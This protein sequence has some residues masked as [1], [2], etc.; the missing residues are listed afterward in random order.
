MSDQETGIPPLQHLY[1]AWSPG[2]VLFYGPS[3]RSLNCYGDINRQS[4]LVLISQIL[5]LETRGEDPI[6]LY[7][8]TDG[9]VLADALA[10]YDTLRSIKSPIVTIATGVCASA[11]LLLLSSGDLR[12]TYPNTIFFYHQPIFPGQEVH[13]SEQ[14]KSTADMY[15]LAKTKY[16]G[17]ISRRCNMPPEQWNE[18]FYNRTTKYFTAQEAKNYNMVDGIIPHAE[19]AKQ[20]EWSNDGG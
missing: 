10:I 7:L 15:E 20:L 9:G 11:G 6:T 4:S 13:S 16:D 3:A 8:N 5:E 1:E 19:K 14:I 17:I 2:D 12:L 18:E